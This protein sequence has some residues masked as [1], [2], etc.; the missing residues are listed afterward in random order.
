MRSNNGVVAFTY[1]AQVACNCAAS[2]YY[3]LNIVTSGPFY[4]DTFPL[5]KGIRKI[6]V[7]TEVLHY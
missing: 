3:A 4:H 6:Q 5:R 1:V 7:I 2:V